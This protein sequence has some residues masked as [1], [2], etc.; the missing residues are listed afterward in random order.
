M[1][2]SRGT[3]KTSQNADADAFNAIAHPVRRQILDVLSVEDKS[4]GALAAP[5]SMSRP[6][7]SQHLR[8]LK[9]AGLVTMTRVGREQ[10]YSICGERLAEV[11]D[12]VEHYQK[13][14]IDKLDALG[15]YLEENE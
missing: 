8:I 1:N 11:Y 6:A 15:Q 2:N 13:F 4:V 3:S 5:F 9:D 7:I 12:W 10:R 14:W